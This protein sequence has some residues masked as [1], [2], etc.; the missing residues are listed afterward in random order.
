MHVTITALKFKGH[1]G[2][3]RQFGCEISIM[4]QEPDR[5]LLKFDIVTK[6][7]VFFNIYQYK[8]LILL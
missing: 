6:L 5:Y 2:L 7:G 1:I 8:I 3:E 4:Y